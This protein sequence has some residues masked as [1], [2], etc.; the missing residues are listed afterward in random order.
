MKSRVIVLL[1]TYNGEKYLESQINSVLNQKNV[2]IK[3]WV[4]DDGS[5]DKTHEILNNYQKKGKLKWYSGKNLKPAMSFMDLVFTAEDAEYYAFCDQ[6]DVWD[7]N[8]L[9]VAISK[10]KEKDNILAMYYGSQRLVDKNLNVIS[11]H[12]VNPNRSPYASFVINNA[13]GCTVVFNKKLFQKLREHR[14]RWVYMHDNWTY[15]VCASL[16][17]FIYV[18]ENPY[19]SYRQHGNNVVG[20]NSNLF[21]KIKRANKL[22]FKYEIKRNIEQLYN[23][24][25]SEMTDDY[26]KI[27]ENIINS[28]E[29]IRDRIELINN[30]NIDFKD[31]GLK[32]TFKLKLI[33]NK[34]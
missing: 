1:S 27:C 9:E 18:D 11:V 14:P 15:K 21:G 3:I 2:E 17:G 29:S 34:M 8:K 10:I 12:R 20:L 13:A 23:L 30:K 32:L 22:I 5:T 16:G 25:K 28:K 31:R 7:E 4:R 26:K 33:L 19:I 6:D 24:Y